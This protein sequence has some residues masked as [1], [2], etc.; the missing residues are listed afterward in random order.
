MITRGMYCELIRRKVGIP[1]RL[2]PKDIRTEQFS[3]DELQYLHSKIEMW[4]NNIE[5]LEQRVKDL[6]AESN[7]S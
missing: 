3:K 6:D 1:R 2:L 4:M 7:Q 5:D